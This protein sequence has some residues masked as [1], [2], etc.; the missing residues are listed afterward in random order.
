MN[1]RNVLLRLESLVKA[2]AAIGA[3]ATDGNPVF[4]SPFTLR[5]IRRTVE[6]RPA[7][8]CGAARLDQFPVRRGSGGKVARLNRQKKVLT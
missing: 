7:E 5:D 2:V 1:R 8:T 3:S 4:E 6:T